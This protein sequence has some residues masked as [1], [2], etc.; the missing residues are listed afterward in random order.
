MKPKHQRL[1]FVVVSVA[2]L[3]AGA[4]F[5]MQAFKQN[6][7]YFYSPSDIAENP[8]APTQKIRMGGLVETGSI[9]RGKDDIIRFTV[10]DGKNS[11]AVQYQGMLPNLFREGQ[12]VIAEGRFDGKIFTATSILAKHD[13]NYMPKEIVESLKKSGHWE[14]K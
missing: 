4:L 9:K 14:G 12:G 2:L 8:P 11:F 7:V 3:C 13:E 6:L 1:I 5:T 10:S